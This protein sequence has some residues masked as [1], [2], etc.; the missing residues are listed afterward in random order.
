MI[1]W[2]SYKDWN[3]LNSCVTISVSRRTPLHKISKIVRVLKLVSSHDDVWRRGSITSC[4]LNLVI[5]CSGQLHTPAS[6]PRLN[7]TGDWVGHTAGLYPVKTRKYCRG[8]NP[9]SLGVRSTVAILTELSQ[10]LSWTQL[11]ISLFWP[12][13][14]TVENY[15][16]RH[17]EFHQNP[18]M[19]FL[20][21]DGRVLFTRALMV[22]WMFK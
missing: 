16:V 10:L 18:L 3:F 12:H 7:W 22:I 4:I 20:Y 2:V 9:D 15:R 14:L 17:T 19:H 6:L 8:S 13:V 21:S 11:V 5:R 1:I